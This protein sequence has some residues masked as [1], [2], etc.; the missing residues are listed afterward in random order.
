MSDPYTDAWAEAVA[1]APADVDLHVTLE[2]QHPAII[3][4]GLQIAVRL[5][6]DEVDR[7]LGIE[8]GALF[9]PGTMQTFRR[10]AFSASA[11]EV[12]VGRTPECTVT[13]DNVADQ[14]TPYLNAAI[15]V[16]ADLLLVYREYRSDVTAEPSYGPI[17]FV[18]RQVT[19]SGST[20]TGKARLADL[21]N[22]SF[23]RRIYRPAQF[24]GLRVA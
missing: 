18:V 10:C 2:L 5:V 20:V 24:P 3:E 21:A 1:S 7:V 23:P 8:P 16:R 22:L 19:I 6:L 9:N 17:E 15:E 11:P 4:A 12:A 14:L 13:I